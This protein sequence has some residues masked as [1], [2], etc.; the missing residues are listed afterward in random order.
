M[1]V[2]GSSPSHVDRLTISEAEAVTGVKKTHINRLLDD[3]HFD[4]LWAMD[5]V[6]GRRMLDLDLCVFVK[7]HEDTG[8]LLAPKARHKVWNMFV[9]KVTCSGTPLVQGSCGAGMKSFLF[10]LDSALSVDMTPH[11]LHVKSNWDKLRRSN[12]EIERDPDIRGGL[13][14]IAGTRIG[15]HEV[16]DVVDRAGIDEVLGMYPSLDRKKVDAAVLY[17]KANPRTGR[18]TRESE[19]RSDKLRLTYTRKHTRKVS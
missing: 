1:E 19:Y 14:V 7:F 13:P 6:S 12:V 11:C 4:S 17:A 15:A 10:V 8:K 3:G 9:E 16:A 5:R 2:L 18:P